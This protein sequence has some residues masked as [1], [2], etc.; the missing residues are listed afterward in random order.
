M[1]LIRPATPDDAPAILDLHVASIRAFGP[2]AYDETQVAA[3]A[4][5]DGGSDRYPI[6]ADGHHLVVAERD[7][8]AVGYG[9]LVPDSSEVRAV[10]VHPDH[11]GRGVGATLH[12]RLESAARDRGLGRL[13]LW[14]SLNAVGFYERMGYDRVETTTLEKEYDGRPV[15]LSVVEMRKSVRA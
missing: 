14:S 15:A 6:E 13:R 7:G 5:K 2:D 8:R 3:W 9:H 1:T 10:Y 4:E 11:A 12:E